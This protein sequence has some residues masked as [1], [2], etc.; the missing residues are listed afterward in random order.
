MAR[1]N[2]MKNILVKFLDRF[3]EKNKL[4]LFWAGVIIIIYGKPI[5]SDMLMIFSSFYFF[6]VSLI[7]V[8]VLSLVCL[9]VILTMGGKLFEKK[10]N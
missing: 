5:L 8:L 1:L 6:V 9:L 3:L 2:K 4:F 7:F 10:N